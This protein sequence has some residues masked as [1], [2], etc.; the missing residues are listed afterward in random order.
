MN[1]K[2]C[3]IRLLSTAMALA[4][5]MAALLFTTLGMVGAIGSSTQLRFNPAT[6]DLS[7]GAPVTVAIRIEQVESLYGLELEL[8]FD[9][10]VVLVEAIQPGTF[11]SADFVVRQQVDQPH[12]RARL[13]YTQLAP[14]APRT[15]SGDIALVR[16]RAQACLGESP[17]QLANVIL[18]D[19]NGTAIPYTLHMGTTSSGSAPANRQISGSIFHDLDENGQPSAGEMLLGG[20]PVFLQRL[21]VEPTG[22][23][24][25]VLSQSDGNFQ[26]TNIPCGRYQLWTQNGEERVLTQ[27]VVL[28]ST[29]D[30]S[31][32]LPVTGTLT[33][34]WQR[35]FLPAVTR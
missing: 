23:E 30:V 28:S 8:L 29:M 24:R 20:W 35:L 16:M 22:P 1:E 32:S 27:T 9:P 12:G 14:E 2:Q 33:Y 6:A 21:A 13:A 34:P 10:S 31:L 11:L 17:L 26:F 4:A 5:G 25:V 3:A 7:A 19:D 18:S 15:G